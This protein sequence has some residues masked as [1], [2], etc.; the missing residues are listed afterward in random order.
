MKLAVGWHSEISIFDGVFSIV[1]HSASQEDAI[2]NYELQNKIK[3]Y[4]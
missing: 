3:T 4:I 2:S 1:N